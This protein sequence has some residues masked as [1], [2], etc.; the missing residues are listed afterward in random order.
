MAEDLAL[1]VT[2]LMD[3]VREEVMALMLEGM[4]KSAS[5]C[6]S[7]CAERIVAARREMQKRWADERRELERLYGLPPTGPAPRSASPATAGFAAAALSASAAGGSG[8][9]A[10]PPTVEP[11]AP[12]LP[13]TCTV[14]K[15]SQP[16]VPLS[17]TG[18]RKGKMSASPLRPPPRVPPV[19]L[20]TH[21]FASMPSAAGAGRVTPFSGMT[22]RSASHLNGSAALLGESYDASF[23]DAYDAVQ[24][25]E[26]RTNMAARAMDLLDEALQAA[27]DGCRTP[28]E[29]SG[30]SAAVEPPP[31]ECSP[32]SPWSPALPASESGARAPMEGTAQWASKLLSANLRV[33]EASQEGRLEQATTSPASAADAGPRAKSSA[34]DALAEAGING[35]S[36]SHAAVRE[37]SVASRSSAGH[38]S[39]AAADLHGC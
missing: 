2:R 17:L 7:L 37:C 39:M 24:T 3:G 25:L 33:Q 32:S 29:H 4:Q 10:A 35:A 26:E 19:A 13:P 20:T 21:L 34:S 9:F 14:P 38:T 12:S 8:L 11:S 28:L 15:I 1:D 22:P 23:I 16:D 18:P 27:T 30:G 36:S 31:R 6:A 5:F